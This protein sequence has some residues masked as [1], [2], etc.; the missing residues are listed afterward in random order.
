MINILPKR[1]DRYSCYVNNIIA[2]VSEY[3]SICYL[4]VFWAELNFI[5]MNQHPRTF[6]DI[7][8]IV[9]SKYIITD[10]WREYCGISLRTYRCKDLNEFKKIIF[11]ELEK[12][13]P[14]GITLDSNYVPWNKYSQI[15]PHCL[16]ICNIDDKNNKF[17]CCDGD[18]HVED[19]CSINIDYLFNQYHDI[20]LFDQ[21][22][23]KKRDLGES[24]K[25]FADII[26]KT[27]P[28]KSE[29][30]KIV[31]NCLENCWN[32]GDTNVMLNDIASSDFLLDLTE[33]CN[34][35]HNFV[36][37]IQYFYQEYGTEL[38][39]PSIAELNVIKDSWDSFK[40]LYIK[41]ILS[42][43]KKFIEK[44]INILLLIEEREKKAT[45]NLLY[46]V[47]RA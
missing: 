32:A 29:D 33:I 42:G 24:L 12:K 3:W 19:I 6:E 16:L 28:R 21:I 37:G 41:A 45:Q 18:F 43:E 31:I 1:Y 30:I 38:F 14:V 44:A 25:Y 47:K 7:S 4:P 10:I 20:F 23:I 17:I 9:G 15:R 35:R 39:L 40:G 2:P 46:L 11:E 5:N 26:Q 22:K 36:K 8:I 34:S 13:I 27:N